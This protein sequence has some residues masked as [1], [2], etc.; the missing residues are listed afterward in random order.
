VLHKSSSIDLAPPHLRARLAMLVKEFSSRILAETFPCMFAARELLRDD[1][2]FGLANNPDT[3]L[4]DVA[5]LMRKAAAAIRSERNQVVVL[6]VE[7][8]TA[9]SLVE[10]RALAIKILRY[11]HEHDRVPWPP[12]APTDPA[13]PRWVFWFDGIDFFINFSTPGHV[14]RQSRNLGPAFTLV[15]QSR[16]TFDQFG[17]QVRASIRARIADH[18]KVPPHPALGS[19]GDPTAHEVAQYF[20]GDSTV[21]TDLLTSA[22]M[23]R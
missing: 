12:D 1:L 23:N 4:P 11:L 15:V 10:E 5:E 8:P 17:D 2:L 13:D 22:H 21:A 14:L 20:L 6:F 16:S 7:A 3:M 9:E 18:D 19:Y